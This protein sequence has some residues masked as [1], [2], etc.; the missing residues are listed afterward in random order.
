MA[1]HPIPWAKKISKKEL[2]KGAQKDTTNKIKKGGITRPRE[3]EKGIQNRNSKGHQ[4]GYQQIIKN[5]TKK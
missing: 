1:R 2:K 4:K 5:E 3:I